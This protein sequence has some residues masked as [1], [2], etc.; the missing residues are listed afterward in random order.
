[1]VTMCVAMVSMC[2]YGTVP[3]LVLLAASSDPPRV[4]LPVT[5]C[6]AVVTMYVTMVTMC[7]TME[8]YLG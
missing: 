4:N 3:G 7:V 6:V 1:M 5:R 2:Y 8:L